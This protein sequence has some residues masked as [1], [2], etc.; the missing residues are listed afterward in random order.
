MECRI[1]LP[2]DRDLRDMLS[3]V[4]RCW[5]QLCARIDRFVRQMVQNIYRRPGLRQTA[6]SHQSLL[7]TVIVGRK[8][9]LLVTGDFLDLTAVA[10]CLDLSRSIF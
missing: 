5:Y 4:K 9:V 3:L 8:Y 10:L 6:R 2:Q 1:L 7:R